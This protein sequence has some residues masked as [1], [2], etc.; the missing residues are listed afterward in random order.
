[1]EWIVHKIILNWLGGP[2]RKLLKT[3]PSPLQT[4]E[5][6]TAIWH[7]FTVAGWN[8]W[9]HAFLHQPPP[10][11][12]SFSPNS[13]SQWESQSVCVCVYFIFM[14]EMPVLASYYILKYYH[15]FSSQTPKFFSIEFMKHFNNKLI[16]KTGRNNNVLALI[17]FLDFF[18]YIYFKYHNQSSLDTLSCH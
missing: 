2:W 3:S 17:F 7:N 12:C 6:W 13:S 15:P 5:T 14:K 16:Y 11:T 8:P 18:F 4:T 1:M 10:F 9:P